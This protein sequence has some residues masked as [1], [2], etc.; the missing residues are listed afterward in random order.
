M[1]KHHFEV[2]DKEETLIHTG[3]DHSSICFE[4]M[5]FIVKRFWDGEEL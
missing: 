1:T 5:G 4:Q 2:Y 3:C